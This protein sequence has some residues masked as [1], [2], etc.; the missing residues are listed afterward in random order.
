M[1]RHQYGGGLSNHSYRWRWPGYWELQRQL[2][3]LHLAPAP[4]HNIFEASSS[5]AP[6]ALAL[7]PLFML[8]PPPTFLPVAALYT[9]L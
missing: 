8:P 9:A 5:D 4:H 3:E 7:L 2:F 1:S 6:A